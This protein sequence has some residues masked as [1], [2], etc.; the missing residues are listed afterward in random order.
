M[1]N[2]KCVIVAVIIGATGMGAEGGRKNVGTV[3]GKHLV[4]IV[5]KGAV[6]GA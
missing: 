3:P 1:C 2:I 5:Q 4:D 6:L